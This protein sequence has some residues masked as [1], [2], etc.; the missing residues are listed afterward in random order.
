MFTALFTLLVW[1][2]S[3]M[4]WS[5]VTAISVLFLPFKYTFIKSGSWGVALFVIEIATMLVL[6]SPWM[7]RWVWRG[8]AGAEEP[9][10]VDGEQ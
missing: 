3:R 7:I 8:R 6:I 2:G 9:S 5:I 4:G 10:T 1:R